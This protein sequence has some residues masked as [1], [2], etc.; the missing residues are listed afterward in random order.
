MRVFVDDELRLTDTLA[1]ISSSAIYEHT[2]K[3]TPEDLRIEFEGKDSPDFYAISLESTVGIVVDNIAMRGSSGTIFTKISRKQL[4]Y[5]F[6]HEPIALVLMQYGGNTVPYIKSKKQAEQYGDWFA[7]QIRYVKSLIPE[8]DVVLIGPSDMNTKEKTDYVTFPFLPEVRDALKAAAFKEG[9]AFWDIY[10]VMGGK[11]SMQSWVAAD[12]PLAGPDYIHFTPR[13]ARRVAELFYSALK[14]DYK[15]FEQKQSAL[16]QSIA[17]SL[18]A[19]T[20]SANLVDSI[21]HVE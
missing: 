12:P 19:D 17:D 1:A 15:A 3:D 8:A 20:I 10:E 6:G 4:S 13:G 11:N 21:L 7:S 5:Q 16:K 9:A 18:A 14:D 2:F